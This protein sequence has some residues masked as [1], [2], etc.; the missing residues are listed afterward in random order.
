[1][2]AGIDVSATR[3]FDVAVLDDDRRVA[4]LAKA[5]DLDAVAVMA[6]GL[7]PESVVA[8]DAPPTPSRGL[9]AEGKRYRVAEEELHK[10]GVSLYPTPPSEGEAQAWM[11][12]GFALYEVLAKAGFP[13][14]FEGPV[15][16]GVS[17]EVYPHL[18]YRTLAG[19]VRGRLS[20]IEWSR[21]ALRRRVL[22]VPKDATQDQLDAIAAALTA[23]FFAH[24]RWTGYGDPREGVI[25]APVADDTD[26]TPVAADQ[27]SFGIDAAPASIAQPGRP[28]KETPFA[29][30][31][32]RFVASIPPG[33][34]ATFGDVARACG[35]ASGSRAVGTILAAHA[36]E[37]P[38]HRV[39]DAK[40]RPS[41]A[42]GGGPERQL[43]RLAGEGIRIAD[44]RV[45][46]TTS[47]RRQA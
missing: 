16:R 19:E 1:M 46:L 47:R 2:L 13:V 23:W 11:R 37:I 15:R 40:G 45:D 25:I 36:F 27:L 31:V 17:L 9:A 33:S 26:E 5:R 41:E 3:G 38:T 7:P 20:K 32:L 4:L 44:G 10:L 35:K 18:T 28:P 34:V 43:E 12:E 24:D 39:V 21:S 22:G 30:R 6:R 29:Q 42:F 8:V 14:F